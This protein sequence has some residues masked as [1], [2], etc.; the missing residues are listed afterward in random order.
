MDEPRHDHL[1]TI[2][3][4]VLNDPNLEDPIGILLLN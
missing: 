2:I 3:L 4:V 1:M